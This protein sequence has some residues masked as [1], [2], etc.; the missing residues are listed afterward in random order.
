MGDMRTLR[1]KRAAIACLAIPIVVLAAF[2]IGEVAA[3]DIS[4]LQHVGQGLPL[5]ALAWLAWKWPLW[6][7]AILI[8][9]TLVLAGIYVGM[10]GFPQS[11]LLPN[12]VLLFAPPLMAGSLFVAA[13]RRGR[14]IGGRTGSSL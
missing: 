3:G 4:G 13:A 12:A 5:V 2:A 11:A 1:L 8:V 7:G 10:S 6:G 9:L 14:M